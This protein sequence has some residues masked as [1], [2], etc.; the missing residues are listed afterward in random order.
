MKRKRS[1]VW[2]TLIEAKTRQRRRVEAEIAAARQAV[3][4]AQAT[5]QDSED[6]V[7][8]RA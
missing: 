1:A 6:S 7:R 4:E 8:A 5:A 2:H 3:A